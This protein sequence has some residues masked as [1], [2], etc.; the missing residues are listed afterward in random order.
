MNLQLPPGRKRVKTGAP[1]ATAPSA[2]GQSTTP[3]PQVN[4]TPSPDVKRQAQPPEAKAPPKPAF[5]CTEADCEMSSAGFATEEAK[6][7][8]IQEEHVRPREEPFKFLQESLVSYLGL[9]MAGNPLVEDMAPTIAPAMSATPSRQG[10]TPAST[11]AATPMSRGASMNRGG[12]NIG[13]K[14]QDSKSAAGKANGTPKIDGGKVGD[15][16]M[17]E[18][19]AT[20][21]LGMDGF[22]N[23]IDP[24]S[25]FANV[26]GIDVAANG[27][28]SDMGLYRSL[29]PNDTPESSKDS[30]SSEPN[31]DISEGAGLD[32]DLDW[33]PLDTDL[34]LDLG[35]F[36]IE[37]LEH[38]E[39]SGADIDE[40]LLGEA[41]AAQATMPSW[42]DMMADPSKPFAFDDSLYFMDTAA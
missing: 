8:H 36:N 2:A 10:Q 12:S 41:M 19:A 23:Y 5:Y 1:L 29:T 27:V 22:A 9:D 30:G 26:P 20:S 11:F 40:A 39:S 13:G 42:D 15:G 28:I 6:Q 35:S 32:I 31:S 7:A 3:S 14:A 16:K 38:V 33:Q 17:G 18:A 21:S 24:Q 34:L 25:L 4:K 37:N